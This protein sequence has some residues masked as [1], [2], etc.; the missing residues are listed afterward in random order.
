MD[1]GLGVFVA[2]G[3]AWGFWWAGPLPGAK[4][5]GTRQ[6]FF[7]FLIKIRFTERT[8]GRPSTKASLLSATPGTRQINFF[9]L[10]G[11]IFSGA[12]LEFFY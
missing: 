10:F 4:P 8:V 11:L 6:R 3:V 1:K 7:I 2:G 5:L 12:N 9:R